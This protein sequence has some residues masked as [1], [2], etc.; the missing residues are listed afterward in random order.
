LQGFDN[1]GSV[2]FAGSFSKV[3]F[4]SLRLGYLVVPRELA[5]HFAAA[6]SLTSRHCAAAGASGTLRF[7]LD[8]LQERPTIRSAMLRRCRQSKAS[9]HADAARAESSG[10]QR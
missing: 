4:P 5:P 9:Q 7:H 3:L 8:R 6:I 1:Y 2:I 10:K